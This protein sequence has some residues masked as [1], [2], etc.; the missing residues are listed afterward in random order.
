MNTVFSAHRA[1]SED[2][3][4]AYKRFVFVGSSLLV[5]LLSTPRNA[6]AYYGITELLYSWNSDESWGYSATYVDEWDDRDFWDCTDWE[7][8]Y[9]YEQEVCWGYNEFQFGAAVVGV[10]ISP[11][12]DVVSGG[13]VGGVSSSLAAVFYY[14]ASGGTG[15]WTAIGTHYTIRNLYAWWWDPYLQRWEWSLWAGGGELFQAW[16]GPAVTVVQI[17]NTCSLP[18]RDADGNQTLTTMV[19][20]YRIPSLGIGWIPQCGDFRFWL[21]NGNGENSVYFG[22]SDFANEHDYPFFALISWRL[23][24]GIDQIQEAWNNLGNGTLFTNSGYRSPIHN[25]DHMAP[26][27][28]GAANSRHLF[29]DAMDIATDAG[30]WQAVRDVAKAQSPVPC[31]EPFRDSGPGH[32]HVDY[33]VYEGVFNRV[34]YTI[35]PVD[36]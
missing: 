16:P 27:P 25:R 24:V 4:S 23:E 8:D 9:Y 20:E 29:G 3:M 26:S 21:D 2:S 31:A 34:S 10:L 7:Y 13:F 30:N 22:W 14:G 12:G 17:N 19:A 35:C 15:D 28:P 6:A 5:L 36:W 33:R 1:E 32:V 18:Y 11:V